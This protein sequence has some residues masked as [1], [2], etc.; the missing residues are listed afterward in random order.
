MAGRVPSTSRRLASET[1]GMTRRRKAVFAL[2]AMGLSVVSSLGVLLAADLYAHRKFQ[3][4]AGLNIWGY[5]GPTVGRKQP[6][7]RRIVVLGESTA[8]GY[9]V[10]W[11]EALPAVLERLLNQPAGAAPPPF[12]VSV[13]NL[14]YNNEGVYSFRYTL[15]DYEYLDHDTALF[16]SGYNDLKY[17]E[18]KNQ[19]SNLSVFR[20]TS[21]VFRLTGYF[22]MLPIVVR[23]KAMAIRYGGLLDDAY[24]GK[25]TVFRPNLA[26]RSTAAA[27]E[28]AT[29]ISDS[30]AR[31]LDRAA[32]AAS[33]GRLGDVAIADSAA[34]ECG[35]WAG[36]CGE[37]YRAVKFAL[38]RDKRV[39][40]VTQPYIN[41]AHREQQRSMVEY[42]R[43]RI[44]DPT[45]LR[46]ANLGPT[47][48]LHDR[49]LAYDGIHLTVAGN[50]QIA[51][52]LVDTVRASLP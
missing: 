51:R 38:D 43:K 4:S 10:H 40:V 13:V 34:T 14:A 37:F 2:L 30:L 33:K 6:G 48:D 19:V 36:Y 25:P 7:E 16:Y 12:K 27:L 15:A 8:F 26:Q 22:P 46:F 23:E 32:P 39:L 35:N 20:H 31:Q 42:L 29:R 18:P 50:L 5:R 49:T 28:A 1:R 3:E 52:N 41:Q 21:W 11:Y 44:A 9:G 47:L 45:R 24:W 17:Y